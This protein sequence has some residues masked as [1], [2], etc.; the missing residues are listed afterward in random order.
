MVNEVYNQLHTPPLPPPGCMYWILNVF[1]YYLIIYLKSSLYENKKRHGTHN[2]LTKP[3]NFYDEN[4]SLIWLLFVF[5]NST[6][7]LSLHVRISQTYGLPLFLVAITSY[8]NQTETNVIF[9]ILGRHFLIII[10]S[11]KTVCNSIFRTIN[12]SRVWR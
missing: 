6:W 12:Y 11:L 5:H 3:L 9:I 8:N 4:L 7:S 10:K 1:I 2:W